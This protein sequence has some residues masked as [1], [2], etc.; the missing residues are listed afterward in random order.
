MSTL[1]AFARPVAVAALGA[2][3]LFAA[4][5][6]AS[7]APFMP[8]PLANCKPAATLGVEKEEGD[9]VEW[10]FDA[11]EGATTDAQVTYLNIGQAPT[12]GTSGPLVNET[13]DAEGP[14]KVL[15]GFTAHLIPGGTYDPD[16]PAKNGVATCPLGFGF[17]V[18]Q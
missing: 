8:D 3:A 2:A 10:D 4:P 13:G 11:P 15:P 9:L 17:A 6:A 16:G 14:E 12:I 1:A 7:A 5:A 18:T